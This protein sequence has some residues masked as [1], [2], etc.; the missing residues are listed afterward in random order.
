M[1]IAA[2]ARARLYRRTLTTVVVSQ[3]FGGAGLAAGITVGAL[4]AEEMLGTNTVAG[5]PSALFTLGSAATA[6][7]VGRV[8]QRSGRRA[9]LS[10][11]F[12]AG[13]LGAAG[14]VVAA[15]TGNVVLLF[16]SLFVYGAGTA[17]NLQ[18]RYAGTDLAQPWQR[19]T[20]VSIAMVS[21]TVGAVAGPN[22][23]GVMGGVATAWGLPALAGPFLL[24]A[25]AF[26]VAGAV[27]FVFLRPDPLL[28]ARAGAEAPL[29]LEDP[30]AAPG[31]PSAPL[32]G[33]TSA[34]ARSTP[35]TI[36]HGLAAG[37]PSW[38]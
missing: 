9:G 10:A 24:S 21:T 15:A 18:A 16:A 6:F 27:V 26:L 20:A 34:P 37:P 5:L 31:T 4:L 23:V 3:V 35:R 22:L 32:P 11:G 13:G 7:M 1:T 2:D 33:T 28:V 25:V 17:S 19:G 30:L 12:A 14:V 38:C 29:D 8:S 36:N